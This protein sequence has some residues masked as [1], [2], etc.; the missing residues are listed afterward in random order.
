MLVFLIFPTTPHSEPTAGKSRS[1]V[2]VT[3]K[4]ILVSWPHTAAKTTQGYEPRVMV[5]VGVNRSPKT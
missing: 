3:N 4:Q 5:V 2:K 1:V